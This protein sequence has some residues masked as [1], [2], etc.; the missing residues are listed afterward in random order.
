MPI[1][2]I[3]RKSKS[4]GVFDQGSNLSTIKPGRN[5]RVNFQF[6]GDLG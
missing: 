3:Y 1:S 4:G 2:R 5:F 6:D